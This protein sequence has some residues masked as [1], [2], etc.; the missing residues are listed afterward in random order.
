M[1][2]AATLHD[3]LTVLQRAE[4]LLRTATEVERY[5]IELG[6]EGRLIEMQLEETVGRRALRPRRARCATT[7][8]RRQRGDARATLA[9]ARRLTHQELLD[10]GSLA[11]LLGYDRKANPHDL[12]VS[13]RGYRALAPIPR[14]PRLVGQK[15]VQ[16]FGDLEEILARHRRASSPR[17][18]ASARTAPPTSARGFDRVRRSTSSSDTHRADRPPA[19][20]AATTRG[21]RHP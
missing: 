4:L 17:S 20:R 5:I 12:H 15:V 9:R 21:G 16:R 10:F 19:N 2:G 6:A 1:A 13:P 7:P 14:L 18:T 3:V 8:S 11:E